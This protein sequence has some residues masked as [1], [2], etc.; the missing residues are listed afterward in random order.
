M[1][2]LRSP[3]SEEG[4]Q[5]TS[6]EFS[7]L[8]KATSQDKQSILFLIGG[9]E[10]I[11]DS[12]KKKADM[13]LSLSKMTFTHEMARLFLIEQIYRADAISKNKTYHR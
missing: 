11:S 7:K 9:P 2:L 6:M 1:I 4:K 8:L 3:L 5:Y 10:G 13:V 12:L